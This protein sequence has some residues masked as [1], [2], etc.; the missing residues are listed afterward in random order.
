MMPFPKADIRSGYRV[1]ALCYE[2]ARARVQSCN[3]C[4]STAMAL[5]VWPCNCYEPGNKD[6]PDLLWDLDHRWIDAKLKW[7]DMRMK[8]GFPPSVSSPT[9]QQE[10]GLNQDT[11][12]E[13]RR[14]KAQSS[15]SKP[16]RAPADGHERHLCKPREGDLIGKSVC[17]DADLDAGDSPCLRPGPLASISARPCDLATS[18]R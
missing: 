2:Y 5:C 18:R 11:G 1:A 7:R 16:V 6:E 17:G 15:G 14:A 10:L 4:V 8:A 3:A 12:F 13:P 9:R